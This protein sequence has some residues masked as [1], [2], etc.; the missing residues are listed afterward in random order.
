MVDGNECGALRARMVQDG[1]EGRWECR[2]SMC[3]VHV[4]VAEGRR[5]EHEV[6]AVGTIQHVTGTLGSGRWRHVDQR[7]TRE[8]GRGSIKTIRVSINVHHLLVRISG[9]KTVSVV[10]DGRGA[11]VDVTG[12][13]GGVAEFC[14]VVK[15]VVDT[16]ELTVIRT[17]VSLEGTTEEAEDG[18]REGDGAGTGVGGPVEEGR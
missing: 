13:G 7:R 2:A 4:A 3:N 8:S 14:D 18:G 17:C 15:D 12:D 11:D 5:D 10:D 9:G 16:R 1:E 6:V